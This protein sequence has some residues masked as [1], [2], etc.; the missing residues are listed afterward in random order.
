MSVQG[1]E[2]VAPDAVGILPTLAPEFALESARAVHNTGNSVLETAAQV[3]CNYYLKRLV[4]SRH[5]IAVAHDIRLLGDAV[6][7]PQRMTLS[8]FVQLVGPCSRCE[9]RIIRVK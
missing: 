3:P 1:E 9:L 6:V 8:N 4:P 7:V 5:C 2:C